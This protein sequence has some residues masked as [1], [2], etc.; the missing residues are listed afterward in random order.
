M[1]VAL[2]ARMGEEYGFGDEL[3]QR[4]GKRASAPTE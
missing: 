3:D 4:S 2:T 1:A